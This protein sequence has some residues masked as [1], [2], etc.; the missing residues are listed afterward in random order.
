M[1][2]SVIVPIYNVGNYVY[3]CV[4]SIMNQTYTDIEII[5]VIDGATDD[6]GLICHSLA[7]SDSRIKIIEQE[8]AGLVTARKK[9]LNLASGEYIFNLD[10]D[11]W[12][13]SDCIEIL[14]KQVFDHNVDI[15]IAGYQREF[16]GNLE[17][18][19]PNIKAGVY[20]RKDY[21]H[22]IYPKLISMGTFFRH[23]I[24]TFSWGKLFKKSILFDV[25]MSVPEQIT[26]GE[27]TVVTYPAIAKSQSISIIEEPVYFYR[28]RAKSMLKVV[29]E[30]LKELNNIKFMID[31][32]QSQLNK[33]CDYD[34]KN[35]IKYY[36]VALSIIRT[37]AFLNYDNFI[38]GIFQ[39]EQI[40]DKKIVLYSSGA[41]GQNIYRRLV[42]GEFNIIGW[43]DE[44]TF[45]SKAFGLP[46]IPIGDINKLNPD[47]IIIA[48]LD[49]EVYLSISSKINN[50]VK[51]HINC[52]YPILNERL[53]NHSADHILG[54]QINE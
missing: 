36:L 42:D 43:V 44:D 54:N 23:G 29:E 5:L 30:P 46:V 8:N 35:Q 10:G 3:Q 26:I 12:I 4:T 15:V 11:D 24:S 2:V 16:I 41:F 9:G 6:S 52:I 48:T 49:R 47:I 38:T 39:G 34:F 20:N 51:K 27:D 28:Q 1:K 13:D 53:I 19:K 18:I 17:L 31:F 21:I 45:E 40:I 25:Q 33:N 32:L 50:L 7:K 22:K 37:G 14:M